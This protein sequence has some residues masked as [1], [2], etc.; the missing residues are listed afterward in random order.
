MHGVRRVL[1]EQQAKAVGLPLRIAWIPQQAS[2]EIYLERMAEALENLRAEFGIGAVAFGDLFLEDIRK[3]RESQLEP[4][5]LEPQFPIWGRDTTALAKEFVKDGYRAIA[6]CVDP[7]QI[8]PGFVGRELNPA[9]FA[10]LPPSADPCGENGE[11][12]TF[13]FDGPIFQN[14]VHLEVGEK[15]NR[16]LFWFCDLLPLEEDATESSL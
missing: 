3:F 8:D 9:F 6:V 14:P 7:N 13:V 16:D 5:G 1:L 2:N 4:L 10:D 15:V 12:H 11:F